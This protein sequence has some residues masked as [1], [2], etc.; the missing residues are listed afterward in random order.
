[1]QKKS[2]SVLLL[3]RLEEI[4]QSLRNTHQ[5]LALLGL[6][7]VGK[8]LSRLDD[9]SDLDFF[10]IVQPGQ[11]LRFID[12]L[13]W[14]SNIK[15]ISY[16]FRN[17]YDGYKLLFE[18]GIFCEFAVFEPYELNNIPFSPGRIVWQQ[19]DF[20][21]Q[22][23][24]P[25]LDKGPPASSDEEW[26]VGEAITNLYVGICRYQRGEKL[27]ALRFVEQYAL[28]RIL[29]LATRVEE[30]QPSPKDPFVIDRRFEQRHPEISRELPDMLQ[31]YSGIAKSVL[32]QLNF[33][34]KH[35]DVNSAMKEEIYRLCHL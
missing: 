2:H 10:A 9:F 22:V 15:P 1:M 16:C 20:D 18:D 8:E 33:L 32:T 28:D 21:S 12:H 30:E 24:T 17:T 27:S 23:C 31:G 34:E 19:H 6:G 11:K 14:L 29:D 25:R 35:F 4:G 7:S 5:A 3:E 26:L 13:D